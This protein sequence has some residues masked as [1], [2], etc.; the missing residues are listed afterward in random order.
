[1]VLGGAINCT[2]GIVTLETIGE[3]MEFVPYKY[4]AISV[5]VSVA[6]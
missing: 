6:V 3:R 4:V 1:M 5:I 2:V